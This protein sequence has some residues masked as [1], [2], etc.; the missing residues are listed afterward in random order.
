M[1]YLLLVIGNGLTASYLLPRS[2][3]WA[4]VSTSRETARPPGI[5]IPV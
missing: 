5:K 2:G 3:E 4:L 1:F